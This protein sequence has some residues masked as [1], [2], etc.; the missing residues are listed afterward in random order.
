[1]KKHVLEGLKILNLAEQYPGPYATLILSDLGADVIN[2]ER[3][4]G[5]DPARQFYSFYESINRNKRSMALDLKMSKG[6]EIFMELARD[7]DVILEGFRPGVAKRLGISYEDVSSINKQII[8]ASIS[9]FGQNGPYKNRP[10]HDLSYQAIAGMLYQQA[11]TNEITNV[12][13]IATGDL[14]SGMFAAI[15]VL[16]G[17]YMRNQTGEGT[18]IDVSMTDGLVSWMTTQLVPVINKTGIPGLP[19]EPGYGIYKT[20]DNKLI[21]IS[22]AHEDWFWKPFCLVVGLNDISTHNSEGRRSNYSEI[23]QRISNAISEKTRE[24][25]E[26]KFEQSGIP[27]GSVLGLKDVPKDPQLQ[28]RNLF[29]EIPGDTERPTRTHVRQPL[30]FKDCESGPT[31]HAPKLGEHTKEILQDLG[32]SVDTIKEIFENNICY[33][34]A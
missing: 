32:Y 10:A 34:E 24:E 15:G 9:G 13:K 26:K 23:S 22:I 17:L 28:E 14:S 7:A 31:K 6:R 21:S 4:N 30:T 27:F 5:G 8:Y 25:W 12:P 18:Y 1:M 19:D 29:V 2:I 20:L 16:S 11:E 33:E 3:P